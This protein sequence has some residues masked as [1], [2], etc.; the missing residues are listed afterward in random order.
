MPPRGW[1]KR[2]DDV[3]EKEAAPSN[4]KSTNGKIN[5][6]RKRSASQV[7]EKD[8]RQKDK[9][10]TIVSGLN[11]LNTN[12]VSKN[13]AISNINSNPKGSLSN[14][15][16]NNTKS[17]ST[18]A[19]N[20]N[21]STCD[22]RLLSQMSEKFSSED[23][24]NG[25]ICGQ[26]SL[27]HLE[28][29]D[30]D[31][32]EMDDF[33]SSDLEDEYDFPF[34]NYGNNLFRR[35]EDSSIESYLRDNSNRENVSN[36]TRANISNF[37]MFLRTIPPSHISEVFS[38]FRDEYLDVNDFSMDNFNYAPS[39]REGMTDAEISRLPRHSYRGQTQ[40]ERRLNEPAHKCC[41]CMAELEFNE[42]LILLE[43]CSHRFHSGC[44][45]SWLKRSNKCPICR[46][47]VIPPPLIIR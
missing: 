18:L 8:S 2:K 20:S 41:I 5:M 12:R 31:E 4:N 6:T 35:S 26:C 9:M 44:L 40:R 11:T 19:A 14:K 38:T 10:T 7:K 21:D 29:E 34:F 22:L 45:E 13:A 1:K 42:K 28:D 25:C 27:D 32:D 30:E 33:N 17:T 24:E 23:Y 16:S 43:N 15:S 37:I 47:A 3:D 36:I 39:R 46:S